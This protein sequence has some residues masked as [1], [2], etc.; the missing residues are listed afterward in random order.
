MRTAHTFKTT[1]LR[2]EKMSVPSASTQGSWR[3]TAEAPGQTTS[4]GEYE[5]AM[6]GGLK[7]LGGEHEERLKW[8]VDEM[9]VK[10]ATE[11]QNG[12]IDKEIKAGRMTQEE[13]EQRKG[14]MATEIAAASDNETGFTTADRN[15]SAPAAASSAPAPAPEAAAAPAAAAIDEEEEDALSE[16]GVE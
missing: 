6:K 5:K 12:L 8:T 14:D 10:G 4:P 7:D 9:G 11:Y 2:G 13:G 16:V 15:H 1:F 3:K